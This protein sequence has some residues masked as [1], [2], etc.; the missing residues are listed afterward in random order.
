VF[1]NLQEIAATAFSAAGFVTALAEN[2]GR[3]CAQHRRLELPP[4]RP[5]G[6]EAEPYL[7]FGNWLTQA[8]A[9]LSDMTLF[10]TFDEFEWVEK[11][12]E[13][14]RLGEEVLSFFRNLIQRGQPRLA[15]LFAGVRT[16][17][18]M[19]HNWPS[20][21]INVRTVK[22]CYLPRE[23]ARKLLTDP[24]P[25]FPL[26]YA[27]GALDGL[28]DATRCQ[29][30][31]LQLVGFELVNYLNSKARRAQGDWLLANEADIEQGFHKA[32]EAG[33]NYFAEIWNSAGADERLALADLAAGQG[34][35]P[36]LGE[37]ARLL[38]ARHL[39]R[40]ALI[41]QAGDGYRL[42]IPLVARWIAEEYPPE[43]VR[44]ERSAL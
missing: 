44:A 21:F 11:A 41:E 42:Q 13:Q 5:E 17:D 8:E 33:H 38:V 19:R 23:D 28:L 2:I 24:I 6:A 22:V 40:K 20:Y 9:A 27:P 39:L 15:L 31:L 35:P 4:W 25:D 16:L 30:Y 37:G 43:L 14:G 7:A 36:E 18:E 1:I 32:L 12:I 10:I 29:P 34:L 26:D 3:Q